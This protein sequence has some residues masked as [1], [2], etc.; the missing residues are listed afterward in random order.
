MRILIIPFLVINLFADFKSETT[1]A[2]YHDFGVQGKEYKILEK[3][4]LE[5]INYEVKN[6]KLDPVETKKTVEKEII[7][8]STGESSLPLCMKDLS[9]KPV[10]DYGKFPEDVYNPAGRL[11]FKKGDPVKSE[12]KAGQELDLCFVDGRND[13]VLY[14]QI[15]YMHKIKPNCT[16]L[17]SGKS[18]VPLRK[19]FED[20]NIYPTSKIYEERFGVKCY[21][22]ILHFEKDTKEAKYMSYEH[23]KN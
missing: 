16:I 18:V 5:E 22:A 19:K 2:V 14:N 8:R 11:I 1:P 21:P 20:F 23:F 9:L 10:I 15:N 7:A 17:V 3:N 12:L 6:F 4:I 13:I